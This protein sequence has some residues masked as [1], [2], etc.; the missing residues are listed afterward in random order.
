MAAREDVPGPVDSRLRPARTAPA[1]S[2][3]GAPSAIADAPPAAAV[4]VPSATAPAAADPRV[5]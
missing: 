2:P 5:A 3:D 4:P 1:P